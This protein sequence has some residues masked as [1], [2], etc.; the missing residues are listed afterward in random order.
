MVQLANEAGVD[1]WFTV[2][3]HATPEYTQN[4]AAYIRDNLDPDL[5]V[6]VELSNELWHHNYEQ[7]QDVWQA[8]DE[9]W[10]LGENDWSA[11][12]A[13]TTKLAT[14]NALIWKEE[15]AD[16]PEGRLETTLATQTSNPWWTEQLLG[17]EAWFEN[18]PDAAIAPSE[19]FDSL[20]ITTYYGSA[21]VRQ[22]ESRDA[23]LQAIED[24][25]VDAFEYLY[26]QLTSEDVRTSIPFTA[27]NWRS[28]A[29]LAEEHGLR[30]VSYEGGSHVH[31]TWATGLSSE[32]STELGE[33]LQ[34]FSRSSQTADLY[35]DVADIWQEIGGGPFNQFHEIGRASDQDSFGL[36][37]GLND[38]NARA[39]ALY[40][41]NAE[42]AFFEDRG[43]EHFQQGVVE[44]GD[45]DNNVLI[46][47]NEEDY[48]IGGEGNDILVGGIGNDGLHGGDGDDIALVAGNRADYDITENDDGGYDLIHSEGTD[49]LFEVE[50]VVFDD[51][52]LS[53]EDMTEASLEDTTAAEI[54]ELLTAGH[55]T[56]EENMEAPV[57]DQEEAATLP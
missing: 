11:R 31:H 48:L 1:M 19:V 49:N 13:Y 9:D 54:W 5:N 6:T 14:E 44:Y 7:A 51:Q 30:L 36:L 22:D 34:A 33:F 52:V 18:E 27:E 40:E 46:G 57:D 37:T 3:L 2:P 32:Q 41:I 55:G 12:I 26:E 4:A 50:H 45:E 42:A 10:D 24:P 39:D 15:F 47:T 56:F 43:G 20:A 28:Q 17:A 23:L 38:T 8:A 35:E 29:E 21:I 53:L 25:D 16:E